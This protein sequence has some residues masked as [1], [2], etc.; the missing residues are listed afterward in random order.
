MLNVENSSWI[1]TFFFSFSCIQLLRFEI[2]IR[3]GNWV[4][5]PDI[6]DCRSLV[7]PEPACMDIQSRILYFVRPSKL[8]NRFPRNNWLD[9]HRGKTQ[10]AWAQNLISGQLFIDI[11]QIFSENW[12]WV[13]T[14][15]ACL[16]MCSDTRSDIHLIS[17]LIKVKIHGTQMKN[18]DSKQP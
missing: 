1:K 13:P 6:K 9:E 15:D 10:C 18:S 16:D 12:R 14:R 7:L 3:F 8:L 4:A 17:S 2:L 11:L 5:D